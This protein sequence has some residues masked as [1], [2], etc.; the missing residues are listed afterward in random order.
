MYKPAMILSVMLLAADPVGAGV[1]FDIEVRDLEQV[2]PAKEW[3]QMAADGSMLKMDVASTAGRG[4]GDVIFRGDRRALLVIDHDDRSYTVMDEATVQRMGAQLSEAQIQ[5]QEAMKNVP[6][7]QRAMVEKMMKD[8]MPQAMETVQSELRAT[9]DEAEVRGYPCV[10]YEVYAGGVKTREIWVTDW[11]NIDGGEQ[12]REAFEGMA[13]FF[14][15]MMDQVAG[16]SQGLGGGSHAFQY[17]NQMDG[18]PVVTTEYDNYGVKTG[19]SLLNSVSE[20]AL[21]PALFDPPP[22]YKQRTM[23]AQ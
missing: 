1:V 16:M 7:E 12:A 2:P 14:S 20:K 17:L 6:P 3:V 18:F 13:V 23:L 9:G 22:G 11:A 10:R 15:E 19:Q 4:G 8:R 21:D 5:M